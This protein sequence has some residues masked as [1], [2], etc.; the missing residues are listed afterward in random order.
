MQKAKFKPGD[1]VEIIAQEYTLNGRTGFHDHPGE[2][3]VGLVR[4]VHLPGPQSYD[5]KRVVLEVDWSL[6]GAQRKWNHRAS[7]LIDQ[8]AVRLERTDPTDEEM[9]DL[10]KSLGVGE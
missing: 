10:Y 3:V 5:P 2:G 7:N 8:D 4:E 9:A 6:E 1:R